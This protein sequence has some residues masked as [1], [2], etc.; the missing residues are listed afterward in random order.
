MTASAP[1]FAVLGHPNKGKSSI[2]ATLAHDDSV[3][4]GPVPGT[5]VKCRSFPMKVDGTVLYTLVDTPGFQ[6]ARGALDWMRRQETTAARRAEVVRDFV[7]THEATGQFPDE[8]ELLAPVVE[9]AGILYVVDG[10]VPYGPEYEPEME[11]LRWTGRP[12]MALINPIGRADHVEEW[13]Q[14]LGQYFHVVRVFDAVTAEFDKQVELLRT[15][16]HL[17]EEW[18]E[19]LEHAAAV[20]G[21]E[22]GKRRARAARLVGG[23]L[24][25]MLTLTVTKTLSADAD[26]EPEK[27]ALEKRYRDALRDLERRC[28]DRVE[29]VYEHVR[30]PRVEDPLD[31]LEEDLFSE[32]TWLRFG[33]KRAQLATLGAGGGA[34]I[35]GTL[36][37]ALGGASL[38]LGTLVGA[39][40]GAAVGWLGA[41]RL[42]E[43]TIAAIPLGGKKLVAGPTRNRNFP[44]VAL[45][46]ARLHRLLVSN[47]AHARRD[48]LNCRDDLGRLLPPLSE[49]ARRRFEAC[50]ERVRKGQDPE[51]AS[52]EL[53]RAL[54]TVFEEDDRIHPAGPAPKGSPSPPG[55][56]PL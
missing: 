15:F 5:T 16:G 22:R 7:R 36:D 34:V 20:L 35:G 1:V 43:V 23:T 17:H 33:L 25:E 50:F 9:G 31:L 8:R 21:R 52:E 56:R 27:P 3:A 4:I 12:R 6:R 19:P 53:S 40:I 30:V 45:G 13:R 28:R 32:E 44:H 11:I 29:G 49:E 38:L 55:E 51:G 41:N 18:R 14:A 42:V 39:G 37:A 10:S 47:R 48:D 46:R 26:A 2:V 54:E 24:T